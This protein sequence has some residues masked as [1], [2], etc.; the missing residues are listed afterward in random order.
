MKIVDGS[1]KYLLFYGSMSEEWSEAENEADMR[2]AM[3]VFQ[4]MHT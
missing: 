4:V 1:S 2:Y 3:L